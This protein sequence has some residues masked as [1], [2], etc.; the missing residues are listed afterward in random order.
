M[1]GMDCFHE[2]RRSKVGSNKYTFP[3]WVCWKFDSEAIRMNLPGGS[4]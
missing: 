1:E 3:E 4:S 2:L